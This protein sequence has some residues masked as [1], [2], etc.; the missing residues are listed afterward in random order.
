MEDTPPITTSAAEKSTSIVSSMWD[1]YTKSRSNQRES[2]DNFELMLD[3]VDCQRTQKDY[4]WMSDVYIP[5]AN[6]IWITEAS[7]DAVQYFSTRDYV[8]VFL[9]RN[10]PAS[11]ASCKAAKRLINA[12]LNNRRIHHFYKYMQS[13]EINRLAGYV[14]A[15]CWWDQSTETKVIGRT[16]VTRMDPATGT[17]FDDSQD[18]TDEAVHFDHF[19]WRPIDPRNVFTDNKYCYSAQDES[20]I[21]IR[22]ESSLEELRANATA[23]SYI[24]LDQLEKL[25]TPGESDT[26]SESYNADERYAK[27]TA[28]SAFDILERFGKQWAIIDERDDSGYPSSISPGLD[29]Y[30]KPLPGAQLILVRQTIAYAGS[31]RVL[32]RFQPEPLRDA[33]GHPYMPIIRGV[34]YIHPTK[35]NGMSDGKY[36]NELQVAIN[37]T[38]NQSF[39]RVKLA[40]MPTLKG[41]KYMCENNDSLYFEPEHIMM[42]EDPK[43]L[44]EFKIQSD[45]TGALQQINMLIGIEQKVTATYPSTMGDP[46][47]ASVSATA[48]AGADM[49]ANIRNSYRSL[50]GDYT[51]NN[52]LYWMI[53]QMA[54]QFMRPATAN[55]IFTPEEVQAFN[56]VGD[57]T[58]Q[59]VTSAIELESSKNQKISQYEQLIGRLIPLVQLDPRAMQLI[60]MFISRIIDLRGDEFR[61]FQ[62]LIDNLLSVPTQPQ[63]QPGSANPGTAA[64]SPATAYAS[65][66]NGVQVS[67]AELYARNAAGGQ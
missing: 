49:R 44:E 42:M 17:Y 34:F 6:A 10:D 29:A 14:Y 2:I 40:T 58:Y 22:S 26:S 62:P 66:Q 54:W 13:R 65:N 51:F 52:E 8:E 47:K 50:S 23:N 33:M 21:I 19:N 59:P 32:I 67:P 57:Y 20:F 63:Q 5:E 1:E 53:L 25:T 4:D 31:S 56:P 16:A 24:N 12:M 36:L 61:T 64:G 46:G 3:M 45:I 55:E 41:N 18:I 28:Y 39:D 37:D 35:K 7:Q 43:Q 11:F 15:I 9:E 38:A 60:T 27:T 30:G 48:V